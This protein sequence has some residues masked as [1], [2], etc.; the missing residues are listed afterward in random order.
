MELDQT[1][2]SLRGTKAKVES[3]LSDVGNLAEGRADR[4]RRSN[5]LRS[6]NGNTKTGKWKRK[7]RGE[8]NSRMVLGDITNSNQVVG[9]KRRIWKNNTEGDMSPKRIKSSEHIVYGRGRKNKV[10]IYEA[11]WELKE[12]CRG[13][14]KEAWNKGQKG[15]S[16]ANRMRY[17]FNQCKRDLLMWKQKA[18]QQAQ[19][20]LA[21]ILTSIS[22]LQDTGDGSHMDRMQ[23]LQRK[24]E[25]SLAKTEMKWKQCAKQH[26]LRNGDKN[27]HFFH[28]QANQRRKTNSIKFISDSAGNIAH[29]QKDIGE[30]FTGFFSSLFTTSL[31]VN[32]EACLHALQP[33]VTIEMSTS[34]LKKFTIE[35]VR[36]AVFQM[37][38]LGSPGPDGFPAQFYQKHWEV[39]GEDVYKFVL[40]AI[41]QGGTLQEV[42]DT[43][44]A[45]I[46]KVKNPIKVTEFRPISLYNVLYKI[47]TKTLAKRLKCIL[48]SLISVNQS[49]FVP[50]RLISNNTLIAYEVLHS[51]QSRMKGRKGFMALKLDMSKAYNRVEWGFVEAV[52]Q[53]IGFPQH[54]VH[55]I[56]KCLNSVS[57][58]ILVNGEPQQKFY[59]SRGIRQGDP[60]SPYI[61]ILCAKALSTL[62]NQAEDRGSLTSAPLGRGPTKPQDSGTFEK[63]LGL[64]VM[65]GRAKVAAFHSLIDRTWARVANW[66]TKHLSNAGKDILLKAVLQTIPT[67]AM[68]IFLLPIA[69]T[70]KMNQL[71]RKFWWGYKEDSSKIHWISWEQLSSGKELGGLGFRDFQSFNLAMFSKQSWRML[72]DPTSL[73][74]RVY[75]QKYFSKVGLLESNLGSAPS[76]AWRSIHAGLAMLKKGLLWRV[77]NGTSINLW[78]EKWI[79]TLPSQQISSIRGNDVWCEVVSDLIDPNLKTWREDL[80]QELFSNQEIEAIKTIPISLGGR[81]DKMTWQASNNGQYTIKSGYHYQ[82]SLISELEGEASRKHSD[83][84]VCKKLWKMKVAPVVKFFVRKA[85]SEALPTC[86]NLTRRKILEDSLCPICKREPE[87]SGRALWGCSAA[88]DVWSQG[89]I[90]VQKMSHHNNLFFNVW[91]LLV[92]QLDQAELVIGTLRA[93]R[94]VTETPFD[95]E[96]QGLLLAVVFCKEIRLRNL[97][98]E[99]DSKQVIDILQIEGSNWSRGGLM[100]EDARQVLNSW[101][102]WTGVH[103]CRE[104]NMAAH[105]LAK[106]ALNFSVDLY[107]IEEC[108]L[109]IQSIVA[110]EML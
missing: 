8:A 22:H 108:P 46:P 69:I 12:E 23:N 10:F 43:F 27:T 89:C 18:T 41:N 55:L 91:I 52:M 39:V 105:E 80:L 42:K 17:K 58:S 13:V 38:P 92:Q 60:L 24:L 64:L 19:G 76:Y 107:D 5:N 103:A 95:A 67:Y 102:Q 109:C 85:C 70:R 3:T 54:W 47:V 53:K 98:L 57:Y 79:P 6:D 100:V 28:M 65:V 71:L 50:G 21:H 56:Q 75:K 26:W 44:I 72:Q 15:N 63:Y 90:K 99:G 25:T 11:G 61:F 14:I 78:K 82:R 110:I 35:E 68:G 30:V 96:A 77:G 48:P 45:L 93:T 88:R 73:V 74:T 34:L 29:E 2:S 37:N 86:A 20:D 94:G 59:P 9:T 49:A 7:A 104:A 1:T 33:Q 66:K 51:M 4:T 84:D 106:S 32:F 62:L 36:E 83:K 16:Q 97:V 81:E 40:Q 87:T 101:S 31:P